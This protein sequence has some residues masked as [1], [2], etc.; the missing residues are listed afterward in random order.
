MLDHDLAVSQT[1][2]PASLGMAIGFVVTGLANGFVGLAA[3]AAV[4]GFGNGMSAGL[5][6]TLGADLAP[7]ENRG[8][9]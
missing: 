7:K 8:C 6:M 3:A 9:A 1:G 4:L 2:T 5:I